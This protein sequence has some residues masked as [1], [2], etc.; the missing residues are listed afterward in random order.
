[1]PRRWV[2]VHEENEVLITLFLIEDTP[3]VLSSGF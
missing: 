1:M 2:H 3:V